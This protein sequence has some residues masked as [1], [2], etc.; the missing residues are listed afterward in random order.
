MREWLHSHMALFLQAA[1][2]TIAPLRPERGVLPPSFWA[3]HG[4][5]VSLVLIVVLAVGAGLLWLSRRPKEVVVLSPAAIARAALEGLQNRG[6]DE[7]VVSEASTVFRHY[8]IAALGL[9]PGELTSRE[10]QEA[11]F[12]KADADAELAARIIGFLRRCDEWKFGPV[13]S[14]GQLGAA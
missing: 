13:H 1:A 8:V 9:P 7:A 10:I 6:E 4:W 14:P 2:D 12:S 3:T 11:L 5:V